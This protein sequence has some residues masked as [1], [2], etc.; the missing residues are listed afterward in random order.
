MADRS[1][2][3]RSV[4]E[5]RPAKA[6]IWLLIAVAVVVLFEDANYVFVHIFNVLLLFIF[7]AVIALILTPV[8]DRMQRFGPFRRHRGMA[9]LT[10]YLA[11]L[12]LVAGGFALVTPSLV[13]QAKQLP[14]LVEEFQKLLQQHGITFTLDSLVKAIGGAQI[15]VAIG[16]AGTLLSTVVSIVLTAVI[17]IYL[18]V[19]GRVLVATA[20]NVFPGQQRRFDFVTLAVGSTLMAYVRGQIIMSFIIG[21][22]TGVALT[23]L[24]VH[25]GALIGLAAF[26]LELIPIVGAIL[27]T[28]IAVIVALLQNPGLAIATLAVGLFGH[29]L[30]AYL[31]GPRINGRATQLHALVAMAALLVGA[32][33][34][35]V[36]GALF[37]VPIAAVANIFLGAAYR[38]R[39]GEKKPMTT[40]ADGSVSVDALPRLGEEVVAVEDE[41]MIKTPVPRGTANAAT[42]TR[43]AGRRT[44]ARRPESRRKTASDA[45]N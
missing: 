14:A 18:V 2:V 36:L 27:A 3:P 10:L 19:E 17:S 12:A 7:A 25:Y 42:N 29:A 4:W 15:G 34:G 22:Y 40:S 35:G 5:G 26:F 23:L 21:S 13:A 20:R 9:A 44:A 6:L 24:G 30:D 16:V 32:E 38:A 8:V 28:V 41:G 31:L 43:A 37:A 33:L 39:R 45:S 11:G 1:A